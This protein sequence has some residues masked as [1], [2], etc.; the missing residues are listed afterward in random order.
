MSIN[1]LCQGCVFAQ[2]DENKLQTG[3]SLGRIGKLSVEEMQDGHM[4]L[5]RFCNTYRPDE[6]LESLDFDQSMKAEATVLQEVYPRIGYFVKFLTGDQ[7]TLEKLETTISDIAKAKPSYIT[8]ISDDTALNEPIWSLFIKYFGEVSE[9]KYHIVQLTEAPKIISRIVDQ[10]FTHAQNGWMMLTS[11]GERVAHDTLDKIHKLINIDM[12]QIVMIE[13]YDDFNGMIFP[14]YVFKFLNGNKTKI[15]ND[16]QAVSDSF[17]NKM[18]EA[19]KRGET[20]CILS[21]EE[22]NAA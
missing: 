9:V 12:Q 10:S 19:E 11:S 22:F 15:F 20:K 4:L 1:T 3:C 21:W 16:E 5:E 2:L 7:S 13:P 17:I 8:V 18:K 6:W 14:A